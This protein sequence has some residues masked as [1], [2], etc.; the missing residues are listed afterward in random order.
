MLQINIP[1]PCYE[2]WNKMTPNSQGAFCGSCQKT[3]VDFTAL[4]DDEILNYLKNNRNT[5][6]C[7]RI[8]VKQLERFNLKIDEG[9]LQTNISL[10]KKYLALIL[11][12]FGTMIM[13][14][15]DILGGKNQ[16]MGGA[17]VTNIK[18][19]PQKIDTV[20]I[21]KIK[22]ILVPET[23]ILLGM[24][25]IN[26]TGDLQFVPPIIDSNNSIQDSIQKSIFPIIDS[27]I[28]KDTIPIK[29]DSCNKNDFLSI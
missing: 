5:K 26:I 14:C 7:G 18:K 15:K 20:H 24:M 13:G 16:I 12:C 3:V 28:F 11:I 29:K 8:E 6:T 2:D 1:K 23:E 10:W 4:T 17:M 21:E 19:I 9:I 27:T 25:P 22:E